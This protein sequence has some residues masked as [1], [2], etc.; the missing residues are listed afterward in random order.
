MKLS[1]ILIKLFVISALLIISNYN[2]ALHSSENRAVFWNHYH[3]WLG[4]LFDKASYL[5]G[6][7]VNAEW[8]PTPDTLGTSAPVNNTIR[9]LPTPRV[10]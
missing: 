2:L 4:G 6:Y 7:V 9:M 1:L 10:R 5:T 8:L 3:V